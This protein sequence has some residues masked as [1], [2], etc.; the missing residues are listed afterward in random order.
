MFT[1]SPICGFA[2]ESP[3]RWREA[4]VPCGRLEHVGQWAGEEG[5]PRMADRKLEKACS[6]A[7]REQKVARPSVEHDEE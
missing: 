4:A 7:E 6:P 1:H 2:A 5:V 3:P